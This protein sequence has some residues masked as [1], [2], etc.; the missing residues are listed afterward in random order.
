MLNRLS[1]MTLLVCAN[2]FWLN[3]QDNA[4]APVDMERWNL[5][6]QATSIG[7]Y[8]GSFNA[9]YSGPK[10]LS[11]K[12]EHDVSLTTTLFFGLRISDNTQFY[13][14]PEIA[15]GR[16]FSGVNGLANASNGELPRVASAAPKP[17]IARL[18]I[19]HDFGFG[20]E[21]EPIEGDANQLGGSR[22]VTRYTITRRAAFR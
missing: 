9:A 5:L 8:H 7:E 2:A 11:N 17:Y 15:G 12:P 14:D 3:A 16:G 4:A 19:T 6:Y 22:P 18:Y 1:M 10:S 21:Q 20:T 13:F